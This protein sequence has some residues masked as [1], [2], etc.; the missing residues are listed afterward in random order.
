MTYTRRLDAETL[1]H[2]LSGADR[3]ESGEAG[4][5]EHADDSDRAF[6]T[7]TGTENERQC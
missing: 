1:S 7:F 4:G 6:R 5:A 3:L 2:C